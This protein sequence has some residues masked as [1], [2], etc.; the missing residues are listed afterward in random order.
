M[1]V[2]YLITPAE[3]NTVRPQGYR[4]PVGLTPFELVVNAAITTTGGTQ[5]IDGDNAIHSFTSTGSDSFV[6][7][8]TG[9]VEVL[10]I[11][12]G[13]GASRGGGGAGGL[14]Y[15]SST[16]VT[17]SSPYT[18][19]V[20]AGGSGQSIPGLSQKAFSGSNSSAFGLEA[21]GGGYGGG[22]T[23]AGD[24]ANAVGGFGGSGGGGGNTTDSTERPG[25]SA[26]PG[27]GNPGGK[28]RHNPGQYSVVGGGGGA[29]AAGSNYKAYPNPA[30][31]HNGPG[32]AGLEYSISGS[33]LFYAGGGGGQTDLFFGQGLGGSTPPGSPPSGIVGGPGGTPGDHTGVSGGTNRGG[34]G[35]GSAYNGTQPTNGPGGSGGSGVVIVRYQ[36]TSSSTN[37]RIE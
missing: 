35:G 6:P 12:G 16:P 32:G 15:S 24:T 23:P 28:G 8:F 30:P 34:G 18:I 3:V 37:Y 19:I 33:P 7:T 36:H 2:K 11:G 4:Y 27:Q 22:G 29:G 26:E 5:T 13:G 25:G 14:I 1:G 10:V 21:I 9:D 31:P 20:G 17:Q